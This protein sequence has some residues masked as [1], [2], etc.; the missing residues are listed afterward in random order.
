MAVK[1]WSLTTP[2]DDALKNTIPELMRD[3]KEHAFMASGFYAEQQSS[4]DDTIA[5]Y[6]G[7]IYFGTTKIEYPG[8]DIV[9]LGTG[10]AFEVSAMTADYYNKILFTINSS[11]TLEATEGTAHAVLGSVIEPIIPHEKYP[12]CLVSVQDDGTGTA[13]TIL[14]IEQDE[15]EQI[16]GVS[17]IGS[18]VMPGFITMWTIETPP[19]GYLECDGSAISR[20]T[21][22]ILFAVI[23]DDYGNGDGSTT[24]NLPDFRGRFLR[25]WDHGS[26]NDPDAASRTDRG[27]GT[28]GD[29]VGTQQGD[30]FE[31]HEHN[32]IIL[33]AVGTSSPGAGSYNGTGASTSAGGNETRPKN[34][35]TMFCIKY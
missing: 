27:D 5:I 15:I 33:G 34:I 4:P 11:G 10:G 29:N 26:G 12:V 23:S 19:A 31:S 13:G 25:G 32:S 21:Y 9:D 6:A 35:N 17:Q 16:Q 18:I 3:V 28:V 20:T 8:L 1:A 22:S 2:A 24:F 7:I 30:E 14:T